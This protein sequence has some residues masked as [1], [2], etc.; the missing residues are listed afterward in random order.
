MFPPECLKYVAVHELC[1]T[2]QKN[3]SAAFWALVRGA[4]PDYARIKR[5]MDENSAIMNM[6]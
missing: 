3:H 5:W 1:H 6:I 2:R 4:V